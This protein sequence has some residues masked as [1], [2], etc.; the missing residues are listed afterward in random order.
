ME[1]FN[2]TGWFRDQYLTEAGEKPTPQKTLA[3]LIS[4]AISQV[5][6]SLSYKELA[7]AISIILKEEYGG[8]N[9]T[10]FMEVLHAELGMDESTLNEEYTNG[11]ELGEEFSKKFNV[12]AHA[13]LRDSGESQITIQERG[14]ID[15]AVFEYMIKFIEEKGYTVNRDQSHEWFDEDPGERYWYPR[16]KFSK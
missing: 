5:D 8:H 1:D 16:I 10:P 9:F 6:E 12:R 4:T 15:E 7:I 3:S 11:N 14:D 2:I 13:S